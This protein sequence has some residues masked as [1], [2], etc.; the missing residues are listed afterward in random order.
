MT[1][2]TDPFQSETTYFIDAENAAEMA[3][4]TKQA[5]LITE[6]MGGLFPEQPDLS[7]VHD[8]LDIACG[9]GSWVLDVARLYPQ[10]RV[11][12][13]DI[14]QLMIEYA[15]IEAQRF[16]VNNASFQVMDVLKSLDFPDGSF[17][18]VNARLLSVFMPP[19]VWPKLMQ[20]SMRIL[21][22][23]GIIRLTE[24]EWCITNG[25]AFEKMNGLITQ[26]LQVA[27]QSFSP[28][29]RHLGITPMLGRFL[30]NAGC[31]GIQKMAH[32]IDF[33]YGM[34]AHNGCY[35]D[36][37]VLFKLLQSFL[38]KMGVTTQEEVD[39]LY[40]RA[41]AEMQSEDFCGIW[42]FLSVWGQKTHNEVIL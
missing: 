9:P 21:R 3:R 32:A 41:L 42:Y 6:C 34:E 29:G 16:G 26:A 2:P 19:A 31:Q 39:V 15:R 18:L 33:S 14:S 11:V 10:T 23:G 20:D 28:D 8:I 35:Q 4:L 27:G 37:M 12:G 36:V 17:D 5:R 40:H 7:N 1:A 13:I 38:I 30:H 24:C 22:L 25:T